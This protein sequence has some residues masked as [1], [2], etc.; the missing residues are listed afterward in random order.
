MHDGLVN[1][2]GQMILSRLLVVGWIV[3]WGLFGDEG[4]PCTSPP[5]KRRAQRYHQVN[6]TGPFSGRFPGVAE[7]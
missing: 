1:F 6:R 3:Q 5:K 4:T 2:K 7:F